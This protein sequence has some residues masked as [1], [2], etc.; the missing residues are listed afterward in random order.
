MKRAKGNGVRDES[1]GGSLLLKTKKIE[2]VVG[3]AEKRIK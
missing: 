2:V 3:L 1:K